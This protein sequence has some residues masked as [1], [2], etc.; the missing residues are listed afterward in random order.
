M[1]IIKYSF[2]EHGDE[3]GQLIALEESK[4]IPF[5][6]K[7]VYYMY[8]TGAGVRRGF[9]SHRTLEQI[10]ICIHG[11]CRIMLDNGREKE[12]ILLDKPYEGI[13]VGPDIWR[14]MYDFSPDAVLLVLASQL[15]DENDYIRSYQQ[16]IES[17]K[18]KMQED[19]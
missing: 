7:R 17:I 12:D 15:Y 16:F 5:T 18:E 8:D 3:R 1:E 14:E 11:S 10:L 19:V 4:E 2:Q 6:I 13:Y 9:H